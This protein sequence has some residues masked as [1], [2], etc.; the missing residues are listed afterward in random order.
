MSGTS[1]ERGTRSDASGKRPTP[2][3]EGTA[4][5][6]SVDAVAG[7]AKTEAPEA[8]LPSAGAP[9]DETSPPGDDGTESDDEAT[10]A[11]DER[12]AAAA[13]ER[14]SFG[15]RLLGGLATL[16]THA[17]AGVAGGLAV[18][19]ALSLGYLPSGSVK[20]AAGVGAIENRV[21]ALESAPKTPDSA[22]ELESLK[23]RLATLESQTSGAQEPSAS[24]ADVEALSARVAQMET[25][26]A[27]MADAAKDG[28]DVA[29]AAAIS[30]QVAEAE[31]RLDKQ[32]ESKVQSE[33]QAAL[34]SGTAGSGSNTKA[35]ETLKSEIASIDAKL[36]AL[37]E[38]ELNSDGVAKLMP[39]IAELEDRLGRI[40]STLPPLVNALD[41]ENA[42]TKK[43]SVAIAYASLREAVNAGRPYATELTTLTALS[44]GA[45]DL[46][47]LI[48]YEDRGIPTVSMLTASFGRLRDEVLSAGSDGNADS[49][50][51][52]LMGNA[53]ALVKIRRIG[54]QAEGD[55]PDAVIARAG[56]DLENGNLQKAIVELES[57]DG[58]LAEIAGPWL[59][60]ARARLDADATLQRLQDVLLVSLA[61]GDNNPSAGAGKE[62]EE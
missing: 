26:L 22:S 10:E 54:E 8:A 55:S 16:F 60:D 44:P 61:G 11:D 42:Q 40:E 20:D 17:L 21:T 6:V 4:T 32:I 52:Q 3:I 59:A 53:Q 48:D 39:D 50:L 14:R 9:D 30:R 45:N 29:D 56:A 58:H 57:F 5:E 62:G 1:D 25:S 33:I 46:G 49:L 13:P 31:Q 12:P 38:A 43:A 27:S 15:S 19:A 23:S 34:A 47:D 51:G 37:A 18:L 41:E 2:T 28:G 7:D 35:I 24:P 36:K